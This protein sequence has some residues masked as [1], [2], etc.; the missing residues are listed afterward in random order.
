MQQNILGGGANQAKVASRADIA[1]TAK[2]TGKT[3][4]QVTED[5]KARGYTIQ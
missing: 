4:Q 1:T 3:E 5:L 2:S